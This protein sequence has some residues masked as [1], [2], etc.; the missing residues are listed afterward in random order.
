MPSRFCMH[1]VSKSG[2][3]SSG[4][5]MRKVQS[6]CQFP[7]KVVPNN[8]LTIGQLLSSPML[9]RTCSKSCML[10]LSI[11]QTMNSRCPS[12]VQKRKRNQRPNCQHLLDY[13]ESKGISEIHLSFIDYAKSFDCVDHDKLWKA[14]REMEIPDHLTCLLRNLQASQEATVRTRYGTTY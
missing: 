5:R 2:R 10:G 3:Q 9:V 7:R 8:M 11:I 14:L 12:L 1:Y 13:R 4:H 6:S